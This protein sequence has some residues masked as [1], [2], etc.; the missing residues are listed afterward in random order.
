MSLDD[1]LSAIR[2]GDEAMKLANKATSAA[3]IIIAM[4]LVEVKRFTAEAG[5]EA[6][7][8]LQDYQRELE[9]AMKKVNDLKSTADE[10]KQV[11]LKSEAEYRVTNAEELVKKVTESFA[12]FADQLK[13]LPSLLP[14]KCEIRALR[15]NTPRLQL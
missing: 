3:R 1:T 14:L 15:Q 11:T 8:Q 4:K 13:S 5:Q 12:P 9:M 7:R 10:R 2:A 6:Q